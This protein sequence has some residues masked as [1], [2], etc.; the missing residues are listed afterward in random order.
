MTVLCEGVAPG[1]TIQLAFGKS[2]AAYKEAFCRHDW[3]Q[4]RI[5]R[6]IWAEHDDIADLRVMHHATGNR[7]GLGWG[8]IKEKGRT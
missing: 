7:S 6:M 4:C 1:M 3:T 5:A 2:A 8:P